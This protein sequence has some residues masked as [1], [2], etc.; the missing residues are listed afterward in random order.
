MWSAAEVLA[1]LSTAEPLV[2]GELV[3]SGTLG[4]GSGLESDRRLAPGDVIELEAGGIGTL[5]STIGER[6]ELRWEPPRR[7]PGVTIADPD[8]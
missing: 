7:S 4:G 5:R 3:G 6:Q 8:A 2:A 1:Y